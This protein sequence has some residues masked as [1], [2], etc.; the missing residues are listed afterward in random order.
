[1]SGFP[2]WLRM[3]VAAWL[4][5]GMISA[6][7]AIMSK[8][9]PRG[10]GVWLFVS[11]VFPIIGPWF[12]W[13]F[14]INRIERRALRRRE[15]WEPHHDLPDHAARAPLTDGDLAAIGHLQPLRTMTDRV[16]RMPLVPGNR[17]EPLHNGENA[18][19][20]M[21]EAI[22]QAKETVTLESYIFDFDET[23]RKFFEA[24][25]S[26]AQRGVRVHMLLDGIGAVG[27]LSRR[28]RKLMKTGATVA[29]FFP[30]GLPFGRVRFNLR[31]HRKIL[32]VDGKVGFTGGMNISHRHMFSS[33]S[34]IRTEDLHF[35]V[36]GPVVGEMQQTFV[37]DW[38]LATGEALSGSDYFPPLD[39]TGPALARGIISGPDE[40][41]EVIHWTLLA[42]FA[43]AQ[44]SV[45]IAT[46]Y[47]V[48]TAALTA[49]INMAALRGIQI[50]LF[51]PAKNDIPFMK[52]VADAY[53][54]TLMEHGVR[55]YYRN[56]PFVHTK[57]VVVDER[58]VWLGSANFDPRSF[59]LNFEF[60]VE[61]YDV[62]LAGEL[63]R[64]LDTL[65][66][67]ST[68]VTPHYLNS[69]SP[70]HRF[71]DG[72]FRMFSPFL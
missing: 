36:T 6:A 65:P 42:A 51:L 2:I 46:P 35:R 39:R 50:S 30:L 12:Y 26:A 20:A 52:Y 7:H 34:S 58:W 21:L 10:V 45:R 53:V 27:A 31:D 71:R 29:A 72:V 47:F 63:S 25:R 33:N 4:V 14:G 48:P 19:P 18:Y 62:D 23:G 64:W 9:D 69:R 11:F 40:D 57:L 13:V 54:G 70:M 49:A 22:A 56:G 16:T 41:F 61:A 66:A 59:R 44:R 60:N 15:R 17:I 55:V 5:L 3:L 67:L 1:M 38:L 68:E 8:R 43:A 24:T 28:G 32:I 37:E